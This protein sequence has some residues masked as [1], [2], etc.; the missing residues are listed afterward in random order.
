MPLFKKLPDFYLLS[1]TPKFQGL[2]ATLDEEVK[3]NFVFIPSVA[4]LSTALSKIKRKQTVQLFVDLTDENAEMLEAYRGFLNQFSTIVDRSVFLISDMSASKKKEFFNQAIHSD[5]FD[6]IYNADLITDSN[7]ESTMS[8]LPYEELPTDE[9]LDT[10]LKS[11]FPLCTA[12]EPMA[13]E[14]PDIT[15]LFSPSEQVEAINT[16]VTTNQ[17]FT[18]PVSALESTPVMPTAEELVELV[19][20]RKY[21]DEAEDYI[22]KVDEENQALGQ[23]LAILKERQVIQEDDNELLSL[24]QENATLK[25]QLSENSVFT[26]NM[27]EVEAE[28]RQLKYD[29]KAME[30]RAQKAEKL[31]TLDSPEATVIELVTAMRSLSSKLSNSSRLLE[32]KAGKE[33]KEMQNEVERL[34]AEKNATEQIKNN[35]RALLG[36][37]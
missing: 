5:T 37:D 8:R 18:P 6:L 7:F 36:S 27:K 28:N 14:E 19:E 17:N 4:E 3:K 26:Q 2:Y 12:P 20:L 13:V 22:Q 1:A 25:K 29:L 35:L 15:P 16:T 31:A 30:K 10:F 21:A 9:T 34:K 24:K 11:N 23:E 33:L 32:N